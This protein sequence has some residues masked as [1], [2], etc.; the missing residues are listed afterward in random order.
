MKTDTPTENPSHNEDPPASSPGSLLHWM[1]FTGA[2]ILAV[3]IVAL[4]VSL[5]SQHQVNNVFS[6]IS[7]GLNE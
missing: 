5:T 4:V 1:V 7:F 6:N 2:L 3:V